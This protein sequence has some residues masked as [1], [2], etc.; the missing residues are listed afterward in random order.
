[1]HNWQKEGVDP[2]KPGPQWASTY[3]ADQFKDVP[4]FMEEY[5]R[6]CNGRLGAFWPLEWRLVVEWTHGLRLA[7][8]EVE[9]HGTHAEL[10]GMYPP[11]S[12]ELNP[13]GAITIVARDDGWDMDEDTD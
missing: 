2:D 7:G 10:W 12:V 9:A 13:G 6:R 5:K 11:H 3:S 1:M 4:T 8:W